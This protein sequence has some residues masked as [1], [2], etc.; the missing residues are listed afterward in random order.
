MLTYCQSNRGLR[1]M[2]R[3]IFCV[4]VM[5]AFPD[6]TGSAQNVSGPS[7]PYA[8]TSKPT[9]CEINILRMEALSKLAAEEASQGKV[10]IAI[11]RLGRQDTLRELNSR[12]LQNFLTYMSDYQ[13]LP[14]DK[15]ITAVGERVS[16]YGR[17]D[18]YIGGKLV[19]SILIAR[20]KDLCVE[21]CE[22]DKRY[23]PFRENSKRR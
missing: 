9:N 8:F 16:G 17:V 2:S 23:F 21:C 3:C 4:L 13:H 1:N 10:L 7:V 22:S 20:N 18:V 11:A 15:L 12:R 5:V 19:D 14:A 6:K